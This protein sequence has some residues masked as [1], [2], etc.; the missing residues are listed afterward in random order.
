MDPAT[1]EFVGRDHG[2]IGQKRPILDH[3]EFRRQQHSRDFGVAP[4]LRAEHAQPH[5]GQQ[6]GV[7][8]EQIAACGIHQPLCCPQLPAHAAA[9]RV[10]ALAQTK[11][12]QPHPDHRQRRINHQCDSRGY[13]DP[14]CGGDDRVA[15]GG[16]APHRVG[17]H[18][19]S[20]RQRCQRKRPKEQRGHSVD[21]NP[22]R[23]PRWSVV[24]PGVASLTRFDRRRAL[25]VLA[26]FD[27]ADDGRARCHVGVLS[28]DRAGQQRGPRPDGRVVTDGDRAD[29]ELIAVDPVPA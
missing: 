19:E 9:D 3:G 7:E 21:E 5:R 4:H 1:A 6:T 12:E 16:C 17:E 28:D 13:R 20:R 11:R 24:G 22:V 8:R 29:M 18:R 15:E 25:P 10:V 26:A 14:R 2:V 23:S 27:F